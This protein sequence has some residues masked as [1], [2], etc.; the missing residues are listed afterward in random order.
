MS[1]DPREVA[2]DLVKELREELLVIYQASGTVLER[3][4][5]A[6]DWRFC[7]WAGQSDDG[8]KHEAD[9]ERQAH[10]FEGASDT[11]IHLVDELINE[12]VIILE[13]SF[14]RSQMQAHAL[15][16]NSLG[17]AGN[18]ST[19]LDWLKNTALRKD[20]TAEV[21]LLAQY[22]EGD[23]P[24]FGV[25]GVFWRE[26]RRTTRIEFGLSAAAEAVMAVTGLPPENVEDVF[27]QLAG[28]DDVA[29]T[30]L[31]QAVPEL[32]ERAAKWAVKDRAKTRSEAFT[33]KLSKPKKRLPAFVALRP[34]ED[35]WFDWQ[36]DDLQDARVVF[37]RELLT[38]RELRGRVVTLE[39][40]ESVVDELIEKGPKTRLMI[41]LGESA[42][43]QETGGEGSLAVAQRG[44]FEVFCAW[45]KADCEETGDPEVWRTY[46]S[47]DLDEPLLDDPLGYEHGDYPFVDFR[48]ER[49]GRGALE[50]RGVCQIAG[51]HQ[52]EIKLQRD[53]RND[54]T[55]MATTP[56]WKVLARRGGAALSLMPNSE[57]PVTKMD[58]IERLDPPPFPNH[59]I[60]MEN[61]VRADMD[62]YFGRVRPDG[63]AT[64][65]ALFQ[66][67]MITRWLNNWACA[68]EQALSLCDQY[69][70]PEEQAAV[71][72]VALGREAAVDLTWQYTLVI[73]ADARDLDME[74]VAQKMSLVRDLM[75]MDDTGMIDRALVGS[76]LAGID[77]TLAARYVRDMG[78]VTQREV[79]DETN[80]ALK[81]AAGIPVEP[82]EHGQNHQLRAQTLTETIGRSP[83]LN[84]LYQDPERAY[85]K[86]SVD[87]R[88][89]HFEFMATQ[90]QNAQTGR[91][92][93]PTG[94]N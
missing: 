75:A 86:D 52:T 25:L 41:D 33:L 43:G 54:Q 48:R 29:A 6:R 11:R 61:S 74:F 37:T 7:K 51:V 35:I 2:D 18:V 57:I 26:E 27:A 10:P 34:G 21:E 87:Q 16:V 44:L 78:S 19:F 47:G 30:L 50:S 28:S 31:R 32:T 56:P 65:G 59:A 92:G 58:E 45:R 8:R 4:A 68:F 1:V 39:W 89:Q 64:R 46:F 24:A 13:N 80:N 66:Q 88:L 90:K 23:D 36:L 73:T 91:V 94:N 67:S 9:L 20:L 12:N 82:K 72:G 63:S 83:V 85:F 79:D 22:Q 53:C 42:T 77:P 15:T 60:E 38:E 70:S 62:S 93:V 17:Q 49:P 71:M 76:L 5:A 69:M 14:W 3:R 55:Q 40:N 84:Q 81:L